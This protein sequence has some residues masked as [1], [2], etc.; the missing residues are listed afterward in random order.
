MSGRTLETKLSR[1]QL[2]YRTTPHITTGVTPA[3]LLMKM[4]LQTNLFRLRPSTST[5]VLLNQDHQKFYQNRTAKMRMFHKGQEV[6]AQNFNGS[7]RWLTG[8][9]LDG[10][11]ALSFLIKLQDRRVIHH[12]QDD[13]RAR[14]CSSKPMSPTPVNNLGLEQIESRLP[15]QLSTAP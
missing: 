6:F 9:V 3:E 7:L 4:K 13:M 11:D 15:Q 5:T 12:H 1:F 10:I 2:S 14:L 8:H